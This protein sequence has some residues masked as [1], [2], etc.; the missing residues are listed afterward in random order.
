MDRIQ[1]QWRSLFPVGVDRIQNKMQNSWIGS[2]NLIGSRNKICFMS[3]TARLKRSNFSCD[4]IC[5]KVGWKVE[6]KKVGCNHRCRLIYR[7][8][9]MFATQKARNHQKKL[10]SSS[11]VELTVYMIGSR[12]SSGLSLPSLPPVTLRSSRGSFFQR[13]MAPVLGTPSGASI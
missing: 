6:C 4:K 12:A 10:L 1:A 3:Y 2:K 8:F 13:L 9:T 11:R 7:H 5:R